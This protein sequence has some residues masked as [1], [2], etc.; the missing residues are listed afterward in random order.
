MEEF[1][2]SQTSLRTVCPAQPPHQ[3]GDADGEDIPEEEAVCRICFVELSEGGQ[4]LKLECSCRGELAFA[5][6]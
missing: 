5:H 6:Q 3:N 1:E 4:T 2:I